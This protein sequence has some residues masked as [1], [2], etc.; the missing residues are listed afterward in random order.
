MHFFG[1]FGKFIRCPPPPSGWLVLPSLQGILGKPLE[2]G[3]CVPC[4]PLVPVS[5]E[6]ICGHEKKVCLERTLLLI[7]TMCILSSINKGG[8]KGRQGC[9]PPLGVQIFKISWQFLSKFGQIICWRPTLEDWSP[10]SGKSWL[11]LVT[12]T[13]LVNSPVNS[14]RSKVGAPLRTKIFSISCSFF[15]KFGKIVCWRPPGRL[16][17]PPGSTSGELWIIIFR[18]RLED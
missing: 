7:L 1:K 11:S 3:V 15:G 4:V 10:I 17:S 6:T 18:W 14:G 13:K 9:G 12:L 8:S 5:Y 16:A 2:M